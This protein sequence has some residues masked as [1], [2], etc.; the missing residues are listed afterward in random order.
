VGERLR[1]NAASL[2]SSLKFGRI[3]TKKHNLN[4]R[5]LYIYAFLACLYA[6]NG[7]KSPVFS[8]YF[9]SIYAHLSD[10]SGQKVPNLDYF[11]C[12]ISCI[13]GEMC[14]K[15]PQNNCFYVRI[16]VYI[17]VLAVKNGLKYVF[18]ACYFRVY[19]RF[20]VK[21][22]PKSPVLECKFVLY[23]RIMREKWRKITKISCYFVV[24]MR[25]MCVYMP[26]YRE[27]YV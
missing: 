8:V 3:I 5:I 14:R 23:M 18:Y 16:F 22:W 27:K 17:C 13:Y 11:M 4:V 15:R 12:S 2:R 21:K 20:S 9:C 10:F 25:E 6:Q 26:K 1:G 19:M 24:Y 7:L